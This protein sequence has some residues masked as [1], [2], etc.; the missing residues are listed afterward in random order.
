[1]IV[2]G[3]TGDG[4]AELEAR[5]QEL[6]EKA[7]AELPPPEPFVVVRPG[8]DP[9]TVKRDGSGWRVTG[10]RVDRW[11]RDTDMDDEHQVETLQ[12]RLIRAGVERRLEEAGARPGDDVTIGGVTFEF[13][14]GPPP[15]AGEDR[16]REAG[17]DGDEA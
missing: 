12:R 3:V 6:V 14:P 13:R 16:A 10:Q 8:R 1:V 15:E 17:T 9:F 5:I 11:T 2:S 4:V 7:R